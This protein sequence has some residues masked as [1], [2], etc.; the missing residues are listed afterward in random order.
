[1]T[2]ELVAI[3]THFTIDERVAGQDWRPTHC[4]DIPESRVEQKLSAFRRTMPT[5]EYK[6]RTWTYD[7]DGKLGDD[8][9]P[10]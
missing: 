8:D 5:N 6:V 1:M 9:I 10:F 3:E 4:D 7:P 2:L